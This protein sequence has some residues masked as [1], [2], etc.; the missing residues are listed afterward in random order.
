MRAW[1]IDTAAIASL[2][3]AIA[4]LLQFA[5][6][7]KGAPLVAALPFDITTL[8]LLL[9][10]PLLALLLLTRRWWLHPLV[11]PP[12]AGAALLWLWL[13]LAGTWSPSRGILAAKLPE[14]VLLGPLMLL[15]GL[16]VGADAG[17]RRWLVAV[18][19]AAGPFVG[20]SVAWGLAHGAVVLGGAVGANPEL[21]RVQYQLAGLA[22]AC[23][24]GLGGVRAVEAN[25]WSGR[26]FW[27]AFTAATAAA[28]LVPGGRMALLSLALCVAL[29]PALRL[30]SAMRPRAALCW[31]LLVA[32]CGGLALA[33][34]LLD[35]GRAEGLRTLERF[36]QGDVASS[37][38]PM[39][40]AAAMA[41]GSEA[42]PFGLG[43][44][45][46]TIAAGHGE[47]RGLYPHNHLL[48]AWAEGGL[49]G[50]G[51]WLLCFGGAALVPL[52]RLR[53]MQPARLARIAALAL[54][55]ALAAMV[56]TDLGNR[57]VWFALGL[58]LSTG[59]VARRV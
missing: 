35:P 5:G 23:A 33:A 34:L 1:R 30:W 53:R 42:L 7:L 32:A 54:P 37:A 6:A 11:G 8:S 45:G 36:T 51:F 20:A 26:L 10:P 48:E 25:H 18:A 58:V 3:G 52:L 15:A 24:A 2:S 41:W 12:L 59:V 27:L 46:F 44:G 28:A 13:V 31:L 22:I 57:M 29:V 21:V 38:R 49:P 40:W 56:S 4:A 16:A 9:L 43:T 50:L 14:V 47:R 17:A 55:V 19:L 39:L